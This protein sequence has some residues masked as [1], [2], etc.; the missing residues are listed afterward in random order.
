MTMGVAYRFHCSV[1]FDKVYTTF[2]YMASSVSG[3]D[4]SNA[5]LLLTTRAGK[6]QEKFPLKPYSKSFIDQACSVKMAGY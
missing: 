5:V 4:E 6:M 2:Y 3:Q 1:L